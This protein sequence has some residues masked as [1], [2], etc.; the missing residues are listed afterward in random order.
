MASFVRRRTLRGE[1]W[2]RSYGA[3]GV[4]LTLTFA[5]LIHVTPPKRGSQAWSL[6]IL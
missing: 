5:C 3:G 4:A 2:Q 6:A 1:A